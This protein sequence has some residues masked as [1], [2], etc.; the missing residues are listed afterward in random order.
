MK[1]ISIF[2]LCTMV[3]LLT[4]CQL[5]SR[6]VSVF[7]EPPLV[8]PDH[9]KHVTELLVSPP[10][11]P[12]FNQTSSGD[13][14][15]V[16]I[17]LTAVEKKIEIEP[18][19]LTWA[20]TFNGS[21]PGPMIVVHQNDYIELTLIN[22]KTNMLVHNIDFHAATGGLGGGDFTHVNPGEQVTIRFKL[23]KT[24]VFVYHCAPG[25]VMT[26]FHVTS[27]MNGAIM[28]LP[29]DGLKDENGKSVHFDKAFYIA[30][31]D[32]YLPKDKNGKYKDYKSP[33]QAFVDQLAIE[34]NLTPTHIVFNGKVGSL[35]GENALTASVGEK[36]LFIT[37]SANI[38]TGIHL[39][40]GHADLVWLGGSFDDKPS[41]NYESWPVTRGSAVAALYQFRVSGN[42]LYLDHNL[43][44]ATVFGAAALLKVSG[45]WDDNLMTVIKKPSLIN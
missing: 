38:D 41:T 11:L 24:G 9:L 3:I 6:T 34:K 25:G 20:L 18:G 29:R 28:V 1:P 16:D 33:A 13:P 30:E 15:V 10:F 8:N 42:Y 17:K 21:V 36:V 4:G 44:K 40:G 23:I 5:F 37:S 14:V 26:A 12:D 31:Q 32:F 22:P 19:I 35:T 43:I 2:F 7:D 39:I 27:G 45:K